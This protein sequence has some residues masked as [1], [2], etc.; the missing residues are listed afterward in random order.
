MIFSTT[1]V[2]AALILT[3]FILALVFSG[4]AA[5]Q[6]F[7]VIRPEVV[8]PRLEGMGGSYTAMEAGFE[9]LFTN[10]AAL[11][12]VQKETSYA[13]VAAIVSGPLFDIPAVMESADF[14]A[15]V[16]GLVAKYNGV[17][18]GSQ[19]TGPLAFGK[20]DKNFGYGVFN[21]TLMSIYV[22]SIT[23]AQLEM[24]EE[25]LLTGGYGARVYGTGKH[26]LTA[27]I[28]MKGFL[29]ALLI[30]QGSAF[31]ILS[32]VKELKP[33]TMPTVMTTGFGFDIGFMYT[34]DKQLNVG[35]VCHDIY[36]PVFWTGYLNSTDFLAGN[37]VTDSEYTTIEPDLS[38]GVLWKPRFPE[39][40]STITGLSVMLDYR[41]MLMPLRTIHR[42]PVLNIAA[43]AEVELIDTVSLR[44]GI[45]DAYPSAGLGLNMRI[46]KLDIAM[47][48]TE[49]G[50]EPG[51]RPLLN[52]ALGLG[53]E[54]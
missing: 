35:L 19:L 39:H 52:M 36:T 38:V 4:S 51:S 46:F 22:P 32:K 53:F 17:Y 13:R 27:G 48:G 40:W 33:D 28:Q 42:N 6:E 45:R 11:A 12:H 15:E 31:G 26:E 9:T 23:F 1:K 29:Q 5:A 10:P 24:G 7:Q 8:S 25:F 50:L 21:R 54:Y 2:R 16:L 20:V 47:Y 18:L 3:S 43:G 34:L 37:A 49:L 30:E 41:N 14:T 44:F